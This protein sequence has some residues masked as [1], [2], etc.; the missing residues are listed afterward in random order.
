MRKKSNCRPQR[1]HYKIDQR[2]KNNYLLIFLY[3]PSHNTL[4]PI[5]EFHDLLNT[6][7]L[8]YDREYHN[9]VGN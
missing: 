7:A 5:Q 9:H 1:G 4:T 3:K 2:Y 6:E 8:N